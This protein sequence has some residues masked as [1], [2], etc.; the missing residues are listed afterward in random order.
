MMARSNPGAM[1]TFISI[2][3]ASEAVAMEKLQAHGGDLNEAVNA[4]FN[5]GEQVLPRQQH[6]QAPHPEW[7]EE[8]EP[9]EMEA[10]DRTEA[11]SS[12]AMHAPSFRPRSEVASNM[13]DRQ[14]TS[15]IPI[16]DSLSQ[17][18]VSLPRD[19]RAISVDSKEEESQFAD[20]PSVPTIVE[21]PASVNAQR[22]SEAQ[23]NVILDDDDLPSTASS[24]FRA[25]PDAR[26]GSYNPNAYLHGRDLRPSAPQL[27][28]ASEEGNAIEEEMLLAAIEASRREAEEANR[29][30]QQG[31]TQDL[32]GAGTDQSMPRVEDDQ[33]AEAVSLSLKTAE[34]EKAWREREG[35]VGR[36]EQGEDDISF[37]EQGKLSMG[38]RQ[39]SGSTN[40]GTSSQVKLDPEEPRKEGNN[41]NI[42]DTG[43]Q[44]EPEE[45]EEEPLLRRRSIRRST[46][47]AATH[48]GQDLDS[49]PSSP[50]P[51]S[52][53]NAPQHNGDPFHEW[54]GISSEEHDE[55]VMLEA[56][57]FGGIPEEAAYRFSYP[58]QHVFQNESDIVGIESYRRRIPQPPSPTLEAQRLLREQQDDEYLAS[59]QADREKAEVRRLEEEAAREAALA[60][61]KRLQEE[62]LRRLQEEEESERQLVAKKAALPPEPAVE[63]ENAVTLLVRMPDGSRRGRRFLKSDRLQSLFDFIDVGGGVK[64]GTYRL[65]RH[66]PRRA[67]T[68]GEHGSSLSELGLTSKQEALFLELI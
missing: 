9:T 66:Y 54:G 25:G 4:Y 32:L 60:E 49:P 14:S 53:A 13:F 39:G 23:R 47:G 68:D 28:V 12:V 3:G 20:P 35:V 37:L 33:L 40:I 67:F 48:L 36:L 61:E 7:M 29:R 8:D 17:P 31:V 16:R 34:Q 56:A 55:A 11:L 62:A 15:H 2:T 10:Q 50:V 5:E 19:V 63:D 6:D 64:P 43:A 46:S 1:E 26:G 42:V 45:P 38:R 65:V 52:T 30:R 22:V 21:V 41:M 57:L 44:E 51:H 18:H 59:L 24:I 58:G 27:T